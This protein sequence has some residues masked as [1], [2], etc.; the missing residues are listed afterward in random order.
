MHA[1]RGVGHLTGGGSA[2][3]LGLVHVRALRVAG[4]RTSGGS[5]EDNVLRRPLVLRG[6]LD[7]GVEVVADQLRSRGTALPAHLRRERARKR[8]GVDGVVRR[9]LAP[10]QGFR[11]SLS[12]SVQT[13]LLE[14]HR[15]PGEAQ[16]HPLVV[17]EHVPRRR[18]LDAL[19]RLLERGGVVALRLG[20]RDVAHEAEREV[21]VVF[22]I[23]PPRN[24]G[25]L[26]AE[27][28][29]VQTT[30]L[31]H[32]AGQRARHPLDVLLDGGDPLLV[33]AVR[34]A[35]EHRHRD[36]Q[37]LRH[38]H[39]VVDHHLPLRRGEDLVLGRG[40]D[41][42]AGGGAH[43]LAPEA[44]EELVGFHLLLVPRR[45][46]APLPADDAGVREAGEGLV[47]ILQILHALSNGLDQDRIGRLSLLGFRLGF[48]LDGAE[49][50]LGH[51]VVT[52]ALGD[53]RG[54]VEA[55]TG[56]SVE[57]QEPIGQEH[58]RGRFERVR[59]AEGVVAQIALGVQLGELAELL[60][61]AG[62]TKQPDDLQEPLGHARGPLLDRAEDA[63]RLERV[64]LCGGFV[65]GIPGDAW[66]DVSVSGR[67]HRT[68][69]GSAGD[70]Q[71]SQAERGRGG[72]TTPIWAR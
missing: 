11:V 54:G 49:R 51:A 20:E 35:A 60:A 17:L 63:V 47:F 65:V 45:V 33:A 66:Q 15:R 62:L 1:L 69:G 50:D 56:E 39:A 29:D 3:R 2:A 31:D 4:H 5:A 12:Q 72:R 21:R 44:T 32:P 28:R 34:L 52:A 40:L 18:R 10:S 9:E 16:H 37:R 27:E 30:R 71:G 58:R 26:A 13:L 64:L 46:V 70:A 14:E 57:V 8:P 41:V 42:A 61:D 67:K 6:L 48:L 59:A 22:G 7:L 38:E 36:E 24:L 53:E 19:V 68:R 55:A 25:R 23:G 43:E